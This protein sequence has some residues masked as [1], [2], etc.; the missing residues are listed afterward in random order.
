MLLF[1]FLLLF[2]GSEVNTIV[3]RKGDDGFLLGVSDNEGI[4]DT[5]R[6]GNSVGVFDVDDVERSGVFVDGGEGTN[7]TDIVTTLNINSG[8]EFEGVNVSE[9]IFLQVQFD[10][11]ANF[12]AGV[13]VSEG[14]SVM[15]HDVGNFV[16]AHGSGLDFAKLEFGFFGFDFSENKSS[17]NVVQDTEIF[18]GLINRQNIHDTSRV[19][20]IFSNF[21]VNLK[22]TK[23]P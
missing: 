6:E 4:S 22:I 5:G 15:G 20:V 23:V 21:V 14:S 10:R 12:D 2:E 7:T 8:T 19:G 1:T 9:F 16:G 17:L 13:G 3:F 18:I 11:V